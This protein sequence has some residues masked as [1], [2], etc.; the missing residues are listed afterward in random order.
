MSE[1]SCP[2]VDWEPL[3]LASVCHSCSGSIMAAFLTLVEAVVSDIYPGSNR[4]SVSLA[5]SDEAV[6]DASRTCGVGVGLHTPKVWCVNF[7]QTAH[8]SI[9]KLLSNAVHKHALFEA[10]FKATDK[11]VSFTAFRSEYIL[12]AHLLHNV[13]ECLDSES[14]ST[15][16]R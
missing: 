12:N 14:L 2:F 16:I 11:F 7:E 3:V 9:I 15:S 1:W 4:A 6:T 8:A 13:D 10:N 5:L